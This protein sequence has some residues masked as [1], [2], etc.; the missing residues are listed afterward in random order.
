MVSTFQQKSTK[1]S[2]KSNEVYL[3]QGKKNSCNHKLKHQASYLKNR[4]H[5]GT[6]RFHAKQS[7]TKLCVHPFFCLAL[8]ES[9]QLAELFSFPHLLLRMNTQIAGIHEIAQDMRS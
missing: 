4:C 6:Q 3:G 7:P 9:V 2:F 1:T 8:R 5:F